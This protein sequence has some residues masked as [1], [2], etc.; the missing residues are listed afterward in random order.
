MLEFSE[1]KI[2]LFYS[3]FLNHPVYAADLQAKINFI[4]CNLKSYQYEFASQK[5]HLSE[6][7]YLE[8]YDYSTSYDFAF[9]TSYS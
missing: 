1:N 3:I 4:S 7:V 9:E 6:A 2:S 5:S 8:A